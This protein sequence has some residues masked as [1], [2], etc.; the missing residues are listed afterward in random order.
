MR[1]SNAIVACNQ[2]RKMMDA[3]RWSQ[4]NCTNDL[5]PSS[6]D[7]DPSANNLDPSVVPAASQRVISTPW[8][9]L[10]QYNAG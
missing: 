1:E 2:P 9:I 4:N 8:G 7:L 6:N 3:E 5:D 10:N